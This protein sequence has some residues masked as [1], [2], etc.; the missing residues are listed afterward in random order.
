MGL[1]G[2]ASASIILVGVVECKIT[3]C[4]GLCL[5]GSFAVIGD[6]GVYGYVLGAYTF[7]HYFTATAVIPGLDPG[8]GG[9][10]T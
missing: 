10:L 5:F 2:Y 9:A 7:C 3:G 6:A 4:L 8:A 1:S